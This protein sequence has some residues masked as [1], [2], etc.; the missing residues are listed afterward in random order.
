MRGRQTKRST[1]GSRADLHTGAERKL[2]T[3][4]KQARPTMAGQSNMANVA[5]QPQ[6]HAARPNHS[7]RGSAGTT[8]GRGKHRCREPAVMLRR[9]TQHMA[10]QRTTDPGPAV[11]LLALLAQV[12]ATT[13]LHQSLA[14]E[15]PLP[16]RTAAPLH[17]DSSALAVLAQKQRAA[18]TLRTD[19]PWLAA[20]VLAHRQLSPCSPARMR[21]ARG[22][23]RS[24]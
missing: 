2:W 14:P 10:V 19:S 20:A 18:T 7:G 6:P 11:L 1:V 15:R 22:A 17:I 16:Q 24:R 12:W 13:G 21:L 4:R 3:E 23:Q 5:T 8:N 9:V